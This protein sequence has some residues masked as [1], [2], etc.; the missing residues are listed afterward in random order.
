MDQ[1]GR[2]VEHKATRF[3][4]DAKS[5]LL[6][7]RN[8]GRT[9]FVILTCLWLTGCWKS[10]SPNG[11]TNVVGFHHPSHAAR[12]IRKGQ[13]YDSHRA[14]IEAR[15]QK[16][17]G[18]RLTWVDGSV[19][20]YES[21]DGKFLL[22]LSGSRTGVEQATLRLH[23]TV[24]DKQLE[25]RKREITAIAQ[26]LLLGDDGT[27]WVC[28]AACGKLADSVKKATEVHDI[29]KITYALKAFKDADAEIDNEPANPR[30]WITIGPHIEFEQPDPAT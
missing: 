9:V 24:S 10:Q 4:F 30:L 2:L 3:V 8:V 27:T 19:S 6:L 14:T 7:A 13:Y 15:L 18:T 12:M 1:E 23:R 16:A 11:P 28:E 26:T 25:A 21:R 22:Q 17:L 5:C 29:G 20:Q